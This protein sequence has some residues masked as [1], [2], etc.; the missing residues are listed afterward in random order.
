[1]KNPIRSTTVLCVRRNGRVVMAADGQ[2][3][4]GQEVLKSSARKIRRLY[5]DR[6]LAGFA[7]STADAFA[8]FSRFESKLEQHNGNLPRAVVELAKEWRTDKVLR[9]LEAL[10]L[11]ADC[12]NMY[13]V[14]G[15]GDVIEPDEAVAA[16]GSGG[17]FAKAAATALL[18]NTKMEARKIVEQA[19]AIAGEICIYT[20]DKVVYEELG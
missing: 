6:V 18:R 13:I 19:M 5:S 8:L 10:L 1:M 16:I 15:S 11:V 9:H 14:S 3:T 12:T 7:G 4:L 20:N 2:V 17:P